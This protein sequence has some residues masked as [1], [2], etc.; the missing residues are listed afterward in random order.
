MLDG[1]ASLDMQGTPEYVI[2]SVQKVN[3]GIDQAV[4][5]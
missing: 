5:S 4:P 1:E 3:V 2:F